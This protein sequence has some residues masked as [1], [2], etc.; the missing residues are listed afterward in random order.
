MLKLNKGDYGPDISREGTTDVTLQLISK[1]LK[2]EH[3]FVS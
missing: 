1:K 2:S 3:C